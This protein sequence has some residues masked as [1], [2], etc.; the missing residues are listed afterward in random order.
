MNRH[1]SQ[2]DF[3]TFAPVRRFQ[4]HLISAE[5]MKCKDGKEGTDRVEHEMKNSRY[6]DC[7]GSRFDFSKTFAGVAPVQKIIADR[8]LTGLRRFRRQQKKILTGNL[9]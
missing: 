6:L 5:L 3:L 8:V 4:F 2:I 1:F 7:F 9:T